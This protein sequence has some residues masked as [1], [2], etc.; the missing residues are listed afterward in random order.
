MDESNVSSQSVS[1][2]V[3]RSSSDVIHVPYTC[4][5]VSAHSPW[6]PPRVASL[7]V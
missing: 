2:K 5:F 7:S 3:S 1:T 4:Y 6:R